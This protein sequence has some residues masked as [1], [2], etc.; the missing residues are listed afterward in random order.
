[1]LSAC[2]SNGGT[3]KMR[4]VNQADAQQVMEFSIQNPSI[5]GRIHMTIMGA[6]MRGSYTVKNGDQLLDEGKLTIDSPGYI[7]KS[8]NG[9][10]EKLTINADAGFIEGQN[11]TKWKLDNPTTAQTLRKW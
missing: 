1:M 9:E 10:E 5:G 8:K 11:G 7:L 2:H 6:R 3:A 4:W